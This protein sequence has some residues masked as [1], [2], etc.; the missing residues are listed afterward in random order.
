VLLALAGC[1]DNL[2]PTVEAAR[3][4]A[5]ANPQLDLVIVVNNETSTEDVRADFVTA[6]PNLRM[7]LGQLDQMPSLHVGVINPDLGTTAADGMVAPPIGQP[8]NGGCMGAGDDGQFRVAGLHPGETFLVEENGVVNSDQG[9]V[10]ELAMLVAATNTRIGCGIQQSFNAI[11]RA[12]TNPVNGPFLRPDADL[13]VLIVGDEDECSVADAAFFSSSFAPLVET[14]CARVGLVCDQSLDTPGVKTNC[15]SDP[16]P[17]TIVDVATFAASLVAL[18]RDPTQISVSAIVG[19]PTPFVTAPDGDSF[20]IA[21]ACQRS[22]DMTNASPSVRDAELATMFGGVVDSI[23]PH[24]LTRAGRDV[25]HAIKR[26]VQDP[27]V[28][29]NA[30]DDCVATIDGHEIPRCPASGTCY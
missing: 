12:L 29:D 18:K 15:H 8:G 20:F 11:R 9:F 22:P 7:V 26:L 3:F 5:V 4:P 28:Y 13:A 6:L 14:T 19:D 23:C 17:G 1:G 10:D 30:S 24:D 21:N 27:C 16:Q 25:G 2:A